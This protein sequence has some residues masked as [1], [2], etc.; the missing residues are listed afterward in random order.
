MLLTI[1]M[2]QSWNCFKTGSRLRLLRGRGWHNS[3]AMEKMFLPQW[4]STKRG[5]VCKRR[6]IS[7]SISDVFLSGFLLYFLITYRAF[8]DFWQAKFASC[9][10]IFSST[11]FFLLPLA[12]S[13]MTL[14]LKVLKIGSKIIF[15]LFNQNPLHTLYLVSNWRHVATIVFKMP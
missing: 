12:A 2:P 4:M 14:D 1:A 8:N 10:L 15:Q 9:G 6:H 3:D 7:T 5:V 11:R 13:K